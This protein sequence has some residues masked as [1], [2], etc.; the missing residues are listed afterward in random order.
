V[1]EL[2]RIGTHDLLRKEGRAIAERK[3]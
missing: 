1:L 2:R 3:A